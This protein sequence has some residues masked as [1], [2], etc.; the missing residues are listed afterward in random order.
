MDEKVKE[1]IEAIEE[2]NKKKKKMEKRLGTIK[3]S[4]IMV[5]D[6]IEELAAIFA[7]MKSVVLHCENLYPNDIFTYILYSPMFDLVNEGQLIPE[8]D[9]QVS[10]IRNEDGDI[11]DY[12]V[13]AVKSET[14]FNIKDTLHILNFTV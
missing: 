5:E 1:T 6:N 12:E 2:G 8:Y 4:G 13:K 7:K 11:I 14:A 3:V 9:I 10:A